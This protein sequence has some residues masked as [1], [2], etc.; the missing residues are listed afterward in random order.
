[1]DV[2]TLVVGGIHTC[3]LAPAQDLLS[4]CRRPTPL[5]LPYDRWIVWHRHGPELIVVVVVVVVVG[6]GQLGKS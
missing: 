2:Q 4:F 1:M 6:D 5:V 3:R